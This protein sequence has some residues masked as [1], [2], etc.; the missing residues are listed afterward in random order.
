MGTVMCQ[1]LVFSYSW[2]AGLLLGSSCWE[3]SAQGRAAAPLLEGLKTPERWHV[4]DGLVGTVVLSGRLDFMVLKIF[5]NLRMLP[6]QPASANSWVQPRS[7]G[8]HISQHSHRDHR[9]KMFQPTPD[10]EAAGEPSA[11]L[12]EA[13]V[14][15][16][17]HSEISNPQELN[18]YQQL[19]LPPHSTEAAF[20]H[21]QES[22]E[23]QDDSFEVLC[24]SS[25]TPCGSQAGV[26]RAAECGSAPS[27]TITANL[28]SLPRTSTGEKKLPINYFPLVE[29]LGLQRQAGGAGAA[30][31][32]SLKG[33]SS[34]GNSTV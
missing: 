22:P 1:E 32:R 12:I 21:T 3:Q 4:P 7:S 24:P 27:Q 2:E 30:G 18:F 19:R 15:F 11:L 16:C 34:T 14:L 13:L 23:P 5:S 31:P 17:L 6:A 25:L 26:F 28:T 29:E 9:T 8:S 10:N 20:A 33:F